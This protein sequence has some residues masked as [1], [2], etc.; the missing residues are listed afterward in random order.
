MYQY[1]SDTKDLYYYLIDLA[2]ATKF[3]FINA[4]TAGIEGN[5]F[6]RYRYAVFHGARFD[7]N[8]VRYGSIL[9]HATYESH[10][11]G[12]GDVAETLKASSL[13]YIRNLVDEGLRRGELRQDL[14]ADFLSY[15]LYQLTVALRDYLSARF[16]FSFK[17]AV[18]NGSG[19]PIPEND[20]LAVLEDMMEI[21]KRG[22]DANPAPQSKRKP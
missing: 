11:S 16:S 7:F 10:E 19:S 21:F 8:H 17:D 5:F 9:Y 14:D 4:E 3:S 1:F 22:I 2:A 18:R 20:L 12:I 13:S 15:A 6:T